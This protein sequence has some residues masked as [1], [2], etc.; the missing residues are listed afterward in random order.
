[1]VVYEQHRVFRSDEIA[2]L[3]ERSRVLI[4]S[5]EPLG[6]FTALDTPDRY[7]PTWS[8]RT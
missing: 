4:D 1:M 2:R 3:E 6:I 5:V 8:K 7:G